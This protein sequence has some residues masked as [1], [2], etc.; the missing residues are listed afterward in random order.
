MYSVLWTSWSP[1]PNRCTILVHRIIHF[2]KGCMYVHCTMY[3]FV[4]NV[5]LS[6]LISQ[7]DFCTMEMI[8]GSQ[9][10]QYYI[11]NGWCTVHISFIQVNF[12]DQKCVKVRYWRLAWLS[13]PCLT[14]YYL[15][16][17]KNFFRNLCSKAG[18]GV[19]RYSL[20][21]VIYAVFFVKI[22]T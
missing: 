8:L 20:G 15:C 6:I 11:S 19:A 13:V 9:K 2:N 12:V 5:I 4:W 22:G 16:N 1:I 3:T 18:M 7:M 14:I 10:W 21:C 17:S